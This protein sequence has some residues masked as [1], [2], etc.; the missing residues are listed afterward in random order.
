MCVRITVSS[1]T[2]WMYRYHFAH[3]IMATSRGV[4]LP[5]RMPMPSSESL[6]MMI[7][8][9]RPGS[10]TSL[11]DMGCLVYRPSGECS[12]VWCTDGLGNKLQNLAGM[13]MSDGEENSLSPLARAAPPCTGESDPKRP[14]LAT[15]NA[16]A[17]SAE[18]EG[19]LPG[20]PAGPQ[21]WKHVEQ[22]RWIFQQRGT[23][24]NR[25]PDEWPYS[26]YTFDS[27]RNY[28]RVPDGQPIPYD[29]WW[30]RCY[31]SL[32]LAMDPDMGPFPKPVVACNEC[33]RFGSAQVPLGKC[34][35]CDNWGCVEHLVAPACLPIQY[36]M[37]RQHPN[38]AI[39]PGAD[40]Q[41]LRQYWV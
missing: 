9:L 6:P 35:C 23:A 11:V 24:P 32:D 1:Q 2:A 25:R 22:R 8:R 7:A 29:E 17:H 4:V 18:P 16:Q 37:C 30:S 34:I 19:V 28:S 20:R 41:Y 5:F 26:G 27:S 12:P 33:Q 39:T 10:T 14:R 21:Q 31:R 38:L 3:D 13:A 40:F 15:A 36:P